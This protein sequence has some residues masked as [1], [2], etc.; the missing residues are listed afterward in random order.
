MQINQQTN[1]PSFGLKARYSKEGEKAYRMLLSS[2]QKAAH[3]IDGGKNKFA[4]ITQSKGIKGDFCITDII[5]QKVDEF[6]VRFFIKEEGQKTF[7]DQFTIIESRDTIK[8]K[9]QN[10]GKTNGAA[11]AKQKSNQN[12]L[13]NIT[14]KFMESYNKKSTK[15]TTPIATDAT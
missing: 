6:V 3:A 15:I 8:K 11:K 2:S 5:K 10:A 1:S 7:S 4:N 9:A 13:E 14:T 12:L